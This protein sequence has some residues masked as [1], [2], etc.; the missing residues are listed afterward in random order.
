MSINNIYT[1]N[2]VIQ[3]VADLT[4]EL[5]LNHYIHT[6]LTKYITVNNIIGMV[7]RINHERRIR[8]P[9]YSVFVYY[10]SSPL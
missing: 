6:D 9:Y 2:Q 3:V 8:L 7:I 4:L 1:Y 10:R 5:L